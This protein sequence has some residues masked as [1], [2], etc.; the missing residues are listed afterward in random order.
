MHRGTVNESLEPCVGLTLSDFGNTTRAV[1]FV[2]DTGSNEE[3]V[4]PRTIID[5]FNLIPGDKTSVIMG[6][7]RTTICATYSAQVEW[8]GQPRDV[9]VTEGFE[10][11]IGMLLLEGSNL[12]VD[13]TPGG[14][15]TISELP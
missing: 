13:A 4:L 7:G 8:H 9:M 11:L 15:V 1:D 6:D 2:I 12:S 14:A 3:I 10:P 5:Q